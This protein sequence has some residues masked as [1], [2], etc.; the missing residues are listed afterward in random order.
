VKEN[1][2]EPPVGRRRGEE[3]EE[4]RNKIVEIDGGWIGLANEK[5]AVTDREEKC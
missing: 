1:G 5:E 4:P 3:A 2:K